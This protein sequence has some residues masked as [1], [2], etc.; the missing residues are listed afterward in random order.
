MR[1]YDAQGNLMRQ[2]STQG[3]MVEFNVGN[4]PVGYYLHVYDGVNEKPEM[5]QIVV[6]R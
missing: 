2:S 6:E 3:D 5:H 1:L 4:L